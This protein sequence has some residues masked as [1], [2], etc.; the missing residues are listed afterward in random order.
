MNHQ[1]WRWIIRMLWLPLSSRERGLGGE[2]GGHTSCANY[3]NESG[4][5]DGYPPRRGRGQPVS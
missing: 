4:I 2:V 5:R 3:L 1:L